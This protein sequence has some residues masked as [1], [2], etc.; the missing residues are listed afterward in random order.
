MMNTPAKTPLT[1]YEILREALDG[2]TFAY[3]NG[4]TERS[5]Y[6]QLQVIATA[7]VDI[8]ESLDILAVHQ[9][10]ELKRIE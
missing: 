1:P 4:W 5:Q 6:C 2:A 9:P 7:L 8:A 3:E 10:L